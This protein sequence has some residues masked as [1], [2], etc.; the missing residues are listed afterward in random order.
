MPNLLDLKTATVGQPLAGWTVTVSGGASG[1]AMV[2][3]DDTGIRPLPALQLSYQFP[4][5]PSTG[6]PA[7]VL[8]SHSVALPG[9][10][11]GLRLTLHAT[12]AAQH[13]LFVLVK[14]ARGVL[15]RG[16]VGTL[17]Y[18]GTVQWSCSVGLAGAWLRP[19]GPNPAPG[20]PAGPYSFEALGLEAGPGGG[21]VG[22]LDILSVG[23]YTPEG[24]VVSQT[25]LEFPTPD[26]CPVFTPGE[27]RAIGVRVVNPS[28]TA[29]RGTLRWTARSWEGRQWR[30]AS[31]VDLAAG[32]EALLRLLG[33]PVDL[34]YYRLQISVE[35]PPAPPRAFERA[36]VVVRPATGAQRRRFGLGTFTLEG[37]RVNDYAWQAAA[38]SRL[39][40]G[41]TVVGFPQQGSGS[42]D[43]P[44]SLGAADRLFECLGRADLGYVLEADR[45]LPGETPSGCR[46]RMVDFVSRRRAG[47]LAWYGGLGIGEDALGFER[48]MDRVHRSPSL[49]GPPNA[50]TMSSAGQ[51][52][53]RR[54]QPGER[55]V[56]GYLIYS[57]MPLFAMA[58]TRPE[59]M[60]A[61]VT[62]LPAEAQKTPF[63]VLGLAE[64]GE[65]HPFT[66]Y[67]PERLT[68]AQPGRLA[69]MMLSWAAVL[70]P[71]D[72]WHYA[73]AADPEGMS[74]PIG[75]FTLD[76]QPK[77]SA[78]AFATAA[79]LLGDAV[80]QHRRQLGDLRVAGFQTGR[81]PLTACWREAPFW[82]Q[83][84]RPPVALAVRTGSG[85][86]R[87]S[88]TGAESALPAG[89]TIQV[90]LGETPLYLLGDAEVIPPA[91]LVQ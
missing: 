58:A 39:G 37:R 20:E 28:E 25:R 10:A 12:E 36:Y 11:A 38:L 48:A 68:R 81:G 31:P 79:S 26:G 15:L 17:E 42:R 21:G 2:Q 87:V 43:Y 35:C 27:V 22:T 69:A 51:A 59:E 88:V 6:A 44:A 82:G 24:R 19:V 18:G 55:P 14:D 53:E 50:V 4:P 57:P 5:A 1:A 29:L 30:G 54:W 71:G 76:R 41:W 52:E 9:S 32:R 85:C 77:P 72:R 61:A 34:G 40:A 49:L 7:Q 47:W 56:A 33:V 60:A 13:R 89:R 78:A 23:V 91:G 16:E 64:A 63:W 46:D 74:L 80:L 83:K 67:A 90:Q 3:P 73:A 62:R 86:T 75:L 45:P 65:K 8:L 84:P 66:D 70:R